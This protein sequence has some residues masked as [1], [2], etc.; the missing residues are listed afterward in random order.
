MGVALAD[1]LVI[2][3]QT[4]QGAGAEA[5][6]KHVGAGQQRIH[7]L[8]SRGLLQ[9]QGNVPL[10]A[11]PHGKIRVD[12]VLDGSTQ[13]SAGGAA[14]FAGQRLHLDH[15]RAPIRQNFGGAGAGNIVSQVDDTDSVQRL[16]KHFFFLAFLQFYIYFRF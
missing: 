9:I 12:I 5:G 13:R 7:Y 10:V 8:A 3:S 15:I 14:G 2:Q 11:V 1:G 16:S 6:H 4:L